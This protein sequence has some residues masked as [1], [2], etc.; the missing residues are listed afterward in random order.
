MKLKDCTLRDGANVVGKG[1]P[2][3]LTV[4]MLEGLIESG[5]TD[6][7]YGNAGGV[8]AYEVANAIA[9]LTDEEYLDLAQPYLSKA[10]IG[11]FLNAKRYRE[12]SVDLAAEKG[13]A[14]LRIGTN[15]GEAPAA[16]AAIRRTVQQGLQ[17]RYALMKAYA[18]TPEELA[19]EAK[20]LVDCGVSELSIMDSA[21]MMQADQ[22]IRYCETLRKAVTV[23]ITFH[24]HNNMGLAASNALLALEHGADALDCGLL[25]MA[26]SAGNAP[27]EVLAA[28]LQRRGYQSGVDLHRL[29]GFLDE[30]LIPA[31]G[32]PYTEVDL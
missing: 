12:K 10:T 18:L 27:T 31:M 16:F 15:A 5:I 25:G 13:L 20:A 9:P 28:L 23:P 8:G 4:M 14:F 30:K 26:R 17:A 22:V 1:F 32:H 19:E 6:I 2:A 11:M 24:G 7:E 21:G 29:L 3:E